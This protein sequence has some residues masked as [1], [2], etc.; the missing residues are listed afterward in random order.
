M[1]KSPGQSF[2]AR[3]IFRKLG[4]P[5]EEYRAL[6]EQLLDLAE[7][8]LLSRYKGNR[9][10]VLRRRDLIDG[11]LHVKTQGYGFLIR[12]DGGDDV[13]ISQKNMGTAFHRDQVQVELWARPMGKL[14]EGKVV[15]IVSRGHERIV[16]M[17]QDAGS[18]C[19]VIP[20]EL[21][22]TRDIHVSET[23]RNE[24]GPGHKVVVEILDWGESGRM[25][26]GRVLEVLGYPDDPDVDV[27]SILHAYDL[28]PEFPK[29][30]ED[31]VSA[32]SEGIPQQER[33]RRQDLSQRL[34]VTID[35]D[36]AKDFDDAVSLEILTNGNWKL[37]VHIADVSYYIPTGS[38]V[39]V[40]A[41]KRG[42]SAY[43]V[44]RVVPM[45]PER[46]SNILCSL[47]PESD[48]LCFSVD[49]E[50][51]PSGQVVDYT[52]YESVI[53]SH[54]R[55]TYR[56]A[57]DIID[58]KLTT[59]PDTLNRMLRDMHGLSQLLLNRWRN[60]GSIDFN[61]PEPKVTLDGLGK[62]TALGIRDSLPSNRLIEAFMLLAN[63]TVAEHV[64]RLR[65]ES[66]KK[67]R[68]VYRVHEKPGGKKLEQFLKFVHAMGYV[69]KTDTH[70][71]PKRFQAFLD[72][73]RGTRHQTVIEEVALRSMM[74][75]QYSTANIGHFGLAF[76]HYTHFTSPIR[77]YPDL[78]VHRLLKT[79]LSE[80]PKPPA[81]AAPLSEICKTA[82]DRE[83]NATRAER[84]SIRSKQLAFMAERVG[85]EYEAVISGVTGF[86]FFAEITEYLVEGLIHVEELHDDYYLFDEAGLRLIGERTGRTFQL[87]DTV[88]V[89][90]ARVLREERKLDFRLIEGGEI[91]KTRKIPKSGKVGKR[92]GRRRQ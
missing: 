62:A 67:L 15:R 75:A 25:P 76:P 39:D 79:Y 83:I 84:E 70:L 91:Q 51:T 56:Q 35:P 64:H 92:G 63:R 22:I 10:G 32:I 37:G 9:Y 65:K 58:G 17:F 11:L 5:N 24:A 52:L 69:F 82:T 42:T 46:L 66:G 80:N 59:L 50:L 29:S 57:Q 73:I 68:F 16:G 44:D 33:D 47:Q 60:E 38:A 78:M 8:D 36:D 3:E 43:L 77:R 21:K 12:D 4:L 85:D 13:F 14:P 41:L 48:R 88:T 55:L 18:Y 90:V 28:N 61:A 71:T 1:K 40:E 81:F 6:K 45:L 53:H 87:G 30:V 49:L 27:L 31:E 26:E 86:G 2:K 19:Y 89:Q 72:Q 54:H 7:E 20:D 74:K 23:N 34:T